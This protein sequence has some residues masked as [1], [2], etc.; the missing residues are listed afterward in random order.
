[1]A[2]DFYLSEKLPHSPLS[3]ET[4]TSPSWELEV[5]TRYVFT[6]LMNIHH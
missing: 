2:F 4:G 3:A 6:L 5:W 1:V